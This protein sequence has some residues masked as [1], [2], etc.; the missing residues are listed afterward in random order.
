MPN[1]RLVGTSLVL[2]TAFAVTG[3]QT[4]GE[5]Q[6]T[7]M[8]TFE[9][10]E[11]S[12]EDIARALRR[13][14]SVTLRGNVVFTTDSARLSPAGEDAAARLAAVLQDNPSLM[15]AVVGYT[16]NTGSF[17]YNLDLSRRR[18]EAMTNAMINQHGV[19]A[20]RLAPVGMG[21]LD[22]VA[23]NDTPEGRA[24]NR[25]VAVILID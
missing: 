24:Q 25:R 4:P 22:P 15:V 19:S 23:S 17:T 2:L 16:D 3:C 9:V 6:R 14:G 8:S 18:A 1:T 7:T 10:A 5:V 11:A 13:D 12:P 20:E 21:E